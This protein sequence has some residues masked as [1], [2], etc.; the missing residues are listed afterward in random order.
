MLRIDFCFKPFND[1]V[2]IFRV[3]RVG[4]RFG[5]ITNIVQLDSI[6]AGFDRIVG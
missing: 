5:A 4:G 6:D 2:N 3:L 1:L